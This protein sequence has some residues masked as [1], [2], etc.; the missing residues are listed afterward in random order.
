M[1]KH[2]EKQTTLKP[3]TVG[4]RADEDLPIIPIK[5]EVQDAASASS[6]AHPRGQ[7]IYASHG[8][9]RVVTPKGIWLVPPTQAIWI[10]PNLEHDVFFPGKVTLFSLFL[11]Y[12]S[13]DRL[14]KA[15]TVLKITTLMREMIMRACDWGEHYQPQDAGYRFMQVLIDEIS[16]AGATHI[17]LPSAQDLRLVRVTEIMARYPTANPNQ[18][19]LAELACVSPR[20][21][22]RLFLSETGMTLG[23]WNRRLL[24]HQAI[25]HL[26]RGKTVTSVALSLGYGNPTSFVAMFK[27]VLGVAPKKYM[28]TQGV[29]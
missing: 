6:H 21:L 16:L 12:S 19:E 3:V 8:V 18:N 4:F 17:D 26:T 28:T 13:C 29:R 25:D 14:P 15:C 22:A 1:T 23:E 20:T 7:L 10:P 24:V 9:V 5:M 11:T 2:K 27:K